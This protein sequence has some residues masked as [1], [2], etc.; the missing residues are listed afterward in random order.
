[1]RHYPDGTEIPAS[2]PASYAPVV[3][4]GESAYMQKHC[5]NCGA[6]VASKNFCIGYQATVR[7]DYVCATWHPITLKK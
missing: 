3:D 5:G 6:F 1:V 2:L 4:N 7:S